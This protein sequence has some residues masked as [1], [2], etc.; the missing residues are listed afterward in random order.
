[1]PLGGRQLFAFT[2][3]LNKII[4]TINRPKLTPDDEKKLMEAQRNNKTSE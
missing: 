1:M 3:K 2:G 4:L